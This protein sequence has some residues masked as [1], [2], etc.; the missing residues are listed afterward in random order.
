[1]TEIKPQ[2][3]KWGVSKENENIVIT[4]IGEDQIV[5]HGDDEIDF[6]LRVITELRQ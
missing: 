3:V 4:P 2:E 1:M 5:L 6:F